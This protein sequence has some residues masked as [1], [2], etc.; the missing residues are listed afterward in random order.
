[1]N[2]LHRAGYMRTVDGRT[3]ECT[4]DRSQ[5]E[6]FILSGGRILSFDVF[7]RRAGI[8]VQV[9]VSYFFL[10]G[11]SI[12]P[13]VETYRFNLIYVTLQNSTASA[14]LFAAHVSAAFPRKGTI[15]SAP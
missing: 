11:K 5:H 15:V 3:E 14:S 8:F 9:N 2:E 10:S 6:P 1:M 13:F 4:H 7:C 12:F